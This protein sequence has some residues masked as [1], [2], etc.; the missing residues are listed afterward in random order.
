MVDDASTIVLLSSCFMLCLLPFPHSFCPRYLILS[1]FILCWDWGLLLVFVPYEKKCGLVGPTSSCLVGLVGLWRPFL[2]CFSTDSYW[3]SPLGLFS[4]SLLHWAHPRRP[5]P[6]LLS[7]EV[8]HLIMA[9]SSILPMDQCVL[10]LVLYGYFFSLGL[11]GITP[12][13]CCYSL[14][15]PFSFLTWI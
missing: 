4:S 15:F 1:F 8:G 12:L 7:L 5:P 3:A 10:F 9:S 2:Y 6:F 14:I 11:R 13:F